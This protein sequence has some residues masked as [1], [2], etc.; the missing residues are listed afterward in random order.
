MAAHPQF[1]EAAVSILAQFEQR[2]ET[3]DRRRSPRRSLKL[4]A[5]KSPPSAPE[6]RVIIHDVSL[7]GILIETSA[8][9]AIGERLQVQ[10]PEAGAVEAELVWTSGRLFGCRF[11][12]PISKAALSAALLKS[13][14]LSAAQSANVRDAVAELKSLR[15]TVGRLT[16]TVDALSEEFRVPAQPAANAETILVDDDQAE[17]EVDTR[18]P[19][20]MRLRIIL[21]LSFGLWALIL[22]ALGVF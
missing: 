12:T 16:A 5:V 18:L 4:E 14:A 21:A 19:F 2:H 20:G 15:S 6:A 9:L 7:T 8:T 13:P 10:M 22:W 11:K 17:D 3:D 1:E